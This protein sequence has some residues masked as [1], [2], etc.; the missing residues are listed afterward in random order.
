MVA[1]HVGG[2]KRGRVT[3]VEAHEVV[4][5]QVKRLEHRKVCHVD[6]GETVV[7]GQ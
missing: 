6:V 3:E 2:L 7:V 4:V 5:G 1:Q